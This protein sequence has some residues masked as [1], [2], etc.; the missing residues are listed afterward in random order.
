[1]KYESDEYID[2]VTAALAE[3]KSS[4]YACHCTGEKAY[5]RMKACLDA[6]L[7]YLRTGAELRRP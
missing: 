7:T 1:M 6:R 2:G 3:S 4:Y 5:E